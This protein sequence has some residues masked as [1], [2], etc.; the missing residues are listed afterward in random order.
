MGKF[1]LTDLPK[2]IKGVIA[3]D[4]IFYLD[5]NGILQISLEGKKYLLV[6][7][8]FFFYRIIILKFS[9]INDIN[10]LVYFINI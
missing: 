2:L 9:L 4:L 8:F 6:L 1:N 5:I 7:I 10:I 3:I